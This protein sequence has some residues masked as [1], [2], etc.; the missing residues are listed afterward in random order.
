[1]SKSSERNKNALSDFLKYDIS[2]VP[3]KEDINKYID[4]VD[5]I[6]SRTDKLLNKIK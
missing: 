1:M 6:K 5:E 3:T 2:L 4:D